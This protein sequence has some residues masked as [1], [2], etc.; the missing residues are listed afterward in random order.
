MVIQSEVG[1]E[2]LTRAVAE[3]AYRA[4]A[5]HVSVEYGDAWIKRARIEHGIDAALGYGP[6][7]VRSRVRELGDS[8]GAAIALAGPAEPGVLAGLD[9]DRL[10]RDRPPAAKEGIRNLTESLTNWTVVPCPTPGLGGAGLPRPRPRRGARRSCGSRS[11][12]SAAWTRTIRW[13]PGARG[14]TIWQAPGE[15]LTARRFDALHLEG[16]G[17]DLTVGLLPELARGTA[18]R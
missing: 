3:H 16:P 5:L 14:S 8:H 18:A 6:D 13:R 4:G 11:R 1:K 12:T 15:R 2:L 17:T 9:S 10:A 7:W